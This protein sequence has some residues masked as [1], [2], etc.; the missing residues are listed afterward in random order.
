MSIFSILKP[1]RLE[2]RCPRLPPAEDTGRWR[3]SCICGNL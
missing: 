1:G 3:R 2:R